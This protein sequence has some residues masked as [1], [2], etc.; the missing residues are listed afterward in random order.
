MPEK[1]S[2]TATVATPAPQQQS[3]GLLDAFN[4]GA[5]PEAIIWIIGSV[6]VVRFMNRFVARLSERV[7]RHRLVFKQ[8]PAFGCRRFDPFRAR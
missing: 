8:R 6:V 4:P 2:T 1:T 7:A 3:P 5:I